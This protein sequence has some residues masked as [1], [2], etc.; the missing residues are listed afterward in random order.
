MENTETA[1]SLRDAPLR[2]LGNI[3]KHSSCSKVPSHVEEERRGVIPFLDLP[4]LAR[5]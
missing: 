5:T 1:E 4:F 3:I 2:D